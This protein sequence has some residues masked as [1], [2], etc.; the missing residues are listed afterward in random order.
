MKI[1]RILVATVRNKHSEIRF[2][3]VLAITNGKRF[4]TCEY[5]DDNCSYLYS[6]KKL[7]ESFHEAYENFLKR[8]RNYTHDPIEYCARQIGEAEIVWEEL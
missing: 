3:F 2:Q 1:Q 7:F 8:I 6:N 4:I 5:D